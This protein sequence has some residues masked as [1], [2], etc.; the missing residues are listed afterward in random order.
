MTDLQ[1]AFDGR[2]EDVM[3]AELK[4]SERAVTDAMR[5]AGR[6][7]KLE[8]RSQTTQ[9]GLSRRLANTWRD[10]VFPKGATSLGAVALVFSKAPLLARVFSEG[11]RIRSK[12]GFYLA[13]PTE[14]APVKG[15]DRQKLTPSNFP[16]ERF[17]KLRFVFVRGKRIGLLVVD[18]V[19]RRK[20]KRGGFT[21]ASKAALKR[22]DF[23]NSVVMFVLVPEVRIKPK[24]DVEFSAEK[25]QRR[26]PFLIL[27]NF[28]RLDAADP[29]IGR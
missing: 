13:I 28:D 6:G 11:A 26:V 12:D 15:R 23:E 3:E 24:I 10:T 21:K 7:L 1:L 16:E 8:L 5:Q 20:G 22:G 14:N 27:R 29:N 2:L 19:R 25:W 18:Q 9:A 17:G 4:K